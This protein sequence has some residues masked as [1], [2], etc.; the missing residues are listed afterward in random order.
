[1]KYVYNTRLYWKC[2]IRKV[3]KSF[4]NLLDWNRTSIVKDIFM[5]STEDMQKKTTPGR[6]TVLTLQ[7]LLRIL[8]KKKKIKILISDKFEE[9]SPLLKS[10]KAKYTPSLIRV[11][12]NELRCSL[13]I[14]IHA[15]ILERF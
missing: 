4:L 1:M 3:N 9:N 14:L 8:K 10:Y 11:N 13:R 7:K 15:Y 2:I 5:I 12:E 6:E